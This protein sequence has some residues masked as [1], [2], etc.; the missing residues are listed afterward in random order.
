MIGMVRRLVNSDIN[1]MKIYY[2]ETTTIIAC[3]CCLGGKLQENHSSA[4]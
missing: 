4:G 1:L 2:E 3:C